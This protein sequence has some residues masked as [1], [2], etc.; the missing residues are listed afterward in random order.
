MFAGVVLRVFQIVELGLSFHCARTLRGKTELLPGGPAW[1]STTVT[2]PGYETKDPL[3]LFYRD[4]MECVEFILK[5]PLFSGK[6][7]YQP[8]QDFDP[9]GGCMYSEW[10]SSDGAWDLQVCTFL[11][12]HY[13]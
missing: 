7:D 1:K 5:N 3:V 12:S 10:I 13:S 9:S 6:I 2:I 8:R 11:V 4:P